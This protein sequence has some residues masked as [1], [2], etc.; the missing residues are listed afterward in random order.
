MSAPLVIRIERGAFT[1]RITAYKR[2][3]VDPAANAW[4][5]AVELAEVLSVTG[6]MAP[7]ELIRY[8]R[9]AMAMHRIERS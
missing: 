3:S 5:V 6:W 9:E 2:T 8:F 4:R 1:V 7:R